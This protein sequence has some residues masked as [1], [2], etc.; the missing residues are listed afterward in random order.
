MRIA[1]ALLLAAGIAVHLWVSSQA[2]L[3]MVAAGFTAHLGAALVSRRWL[4]RSGS[5]PAS[6]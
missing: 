4:V 3:G 6:E 2:G 5:G 1:F